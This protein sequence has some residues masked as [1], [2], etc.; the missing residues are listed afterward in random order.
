MRSTPALLPALRLAFLLA[1][2]LAP[3]AARADEPPPAAPKPAEAKPAEKPADKKA[4]PTYHGEIEGIFQRRCQTCHRP[5]AIGPMP[6]TSYKEVAGQAA[7]IHEVV[8]TRRMPPWHADP[9][10]NTFANS[11]RLPD[12]ERQAI[13]DWVDA[14]APQGDPKQ[15]P[16]PVTWPDAKAWRIGEPDAVLELPKAFTVPATGVVQYQY[17]YVK[18]DFDA[19]K[20]I[21]SMEVQIGAPTV[22]HHVLV[23]VI[24][25][26]RGKSPRVRGGLRGYFASAL[27]GDSIA[28]YPAGTAKWLPKGSTLVFQIHYTPDGTE[29]VDR[30]KLGLRFAKPEEK[31]TRRARTLALSTTSFAIPAGASDHPVRAHYDFQDDTILFGLTPHMHLRGKTFR[32]ALRYPD[33]KT[34][35]LLEIPRWD[36]NW[37]NTYRFE[38][39]L[40]VPK[41]SRMIGVATFDNSDKNPANP[42]PSRVVRFGEQTW[43][44]MMIGYLETV[45]AL[46][47][48]RAAWEKS[49]AEAANPG[50]EKPEAGKPEAGKEGQR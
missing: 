12:A 22:V 6:F 4:A 17:T 28:P 8:T 27:P 35:P 41:G 48:D 50:A 29:R 47:E 32:Y 34:V 5:G 9:K 26:D 1:L 43:D 19:D 10:V 31:I 39:P 23:F 36:F 40:F 21:K 24:Y 44:E 45:D 2:L 33:G 30:C 14:G 3:G 7:M 18:T 15:A 20:W 46:P 37:Q 13:L 11:R 38:Q 42:D 49:Q 25:P 16:A